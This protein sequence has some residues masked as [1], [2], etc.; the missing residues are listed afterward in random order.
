MMMASS[1]AVGT[2][3]VSQ[4]DASF[5]VRRTADACVVAIQTT[6]AAA[7]PV[8]VTVTVLSGGRVLRIRHRHRI[9]E[10]QRLS[11]GDEIR[12]VDRQVGQLSS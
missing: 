5:H 9:G 12:Q 7:V 6:A 4:F 3:P 2:V 1:V 11:V 8:I 10:R